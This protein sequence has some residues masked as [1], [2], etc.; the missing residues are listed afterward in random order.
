MEKITC[1][2]CNN[3]KRRKDFYYNRTRKCYMDSC[4]KCNAQMCLIYQTRKRQEKDAKF[5]FTVRAGGIR[6]DAK[7]KGIPA[8]EGLSK[9]LLSLW[10]ECE[11][12]CYYTGRKLNL[13]GKY[14]TDPNAATVDRLVPAL[15]Y[16]AGNMVLA[17][18][19]ANRVKQN[20]SI[21]ELF[22]LI[23]EIRAF[24]PGGK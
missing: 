19:I 24:R 14:H 13:D 9:Y 22:S 21:T 15:G 17:S 2:K 18:G 7:A 6:R 20:L 1:T 12:K 4:K 8:M 23:D 10:I 5:I 3:P 16:V 11:G